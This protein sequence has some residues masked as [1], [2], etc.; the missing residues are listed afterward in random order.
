M[1]GWSKHEEL[2]EIRGSEHQASCSLSSSEFV[3]L[4]P[5][6][7][8][9]FTSEKFS[10]AGTSE[11]GLGRISCAS[12]RL[13][14]VISVRPAARDSALGTPGDFVPCHRGMWHRKVILEVSLALKTSNPY[15]LQQS[16]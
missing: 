3:V 4:S 5:G 10:C 9:L 12:A 6:M 15:N 14:K 1:N 13:G 16:N 7:R 2:L 8:K 11:R